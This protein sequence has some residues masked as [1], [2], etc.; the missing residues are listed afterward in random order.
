ME[1]SKRKRHDADFK[2]QAV[3]LAESSGKTD[4]AIEEELGVY[5]GALSQWRRELKGDPANAFPGIGRLKPEDEEMR[6]LRRENEIL[7]EERDILK[8]AVAIFSKKPKPYM[9]L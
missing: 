9:P 8:K 2:R 7:R 6:R 4:R 5:Q 3:A 1:E